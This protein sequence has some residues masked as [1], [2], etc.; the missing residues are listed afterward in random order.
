MS[1][2][3]PFEDHTLPNGLRV[4]VQPDST[5]P[6]VTVNLWVGVGSRHEEKGRTGFAHLFE[7]LMFQGSEHVANGEHFQALMG[8]GGRLNATTWFDRTNYFET[9]PSGALELALWLEADRH[10]NLLA[11]VTQEN[12][13]NQRDVVKEEKRQRYDNQPYGQAMT[14]VYANVFPEGH[15]YHHPTIGSMEDLDA[16]SV[17]DVHDFFRR[18]YAPDN[19]VLTLV[20]DVTIE[21]GLE[22]AERYFGHIDHRAEPRRAPVDPLPP[23]AQPVRE[24]ITDEVPNDRIHLA[25]RLPAEGGDTRD[26][27]LAASMALDCLGGLSFSPLEQHLVREQQRANAV[28]VGAMGFVDG[29]SLG[30]VIVDV[31]DGVDTD[32]LEEQVCAEL[33]AFADAGPTPE[34]MEAVRAQAERAWLSALAA[35]DE[36]ADLISHYTLLHDDPG[37]I[38]TFLERLAAVTPEAVRAAADRWLR[39]QSRAAVVYRATQQQEEA[40]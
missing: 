27:F 9:V 30:L 33:T 36:R 6:T 20:G 31:A 7:H 14:R 2:D 15:P 11:A 13:D 1:L 29:V 38:N 19:T 3:F 32:E 34:Q 17:Q 40:A 5:T 39:P 24:E 23:L 26:D 21:R 25:F 37:Y 22:L 35:K 28:D 12:L 16:A 18:H 4:I 10:A 8:V